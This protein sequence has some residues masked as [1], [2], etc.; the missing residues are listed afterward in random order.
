MGLAMARPDQ[1]RAQ[2]QALYRRAR[3]SGQPD[4]SLIH[5]LHAVELEAQADGLER[6]EIPEAH[7][8]DFRWSG[9]DRRRA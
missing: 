8:I 2:A 4:E 5:V 9:R 7:V 3:T 6:G 1:L